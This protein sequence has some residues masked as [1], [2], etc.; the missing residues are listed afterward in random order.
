MIY[1][2]TINPAIDIAMHMTSSLKVGELNRSI[3]DD[4]S[5]GG[6]GINIATV[7]NNLGKDVTP[8][9]V[10]AGY[11]GK[12]VK[13]YITSTFRHY[14]LIDVD[15]GLT[16]F[17]I[18]VIDEKETQLNG[19]GPIITDD[20]VDRIIDILKDIKD[21]DYLCISGSIPAN[22]NNDVYARIISRLNNNPRII[23]D[24]DKQLL[25]NTLEY[26]P[27]MIKPNLDELR[28][29]FDIE[30]NSKE[31]IKQYLLRLQDLGS[32]NILCSL[33]KDGAILLDENKEYHYMDTIKG[34]AINTLG[35]GDSM[36]AGFIYEYDR[37][38]DYL[39]ALKMAIACGS[40]TAFSDN[41][42]NKDEIIET[43]NHL[44][45]R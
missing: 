35:S 19:N 12:I 23:I 27:F 6:K 2:L 13:D 34:K 43:Y 8:V 40:A 31:E 10:T 9:V 45:N 17:K 26:K 25:F 3:K 28:S 37:N 16:R 42:A 33:G 24:T 15:K 41:L 20:D 38:H 4:I 22:L 29:Y 39:K 44:T 21:D 36:I 1:T 18:N 7:L 5:I 11:T 32:R 30:I 14:H